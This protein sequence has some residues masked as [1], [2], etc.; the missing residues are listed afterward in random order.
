MKY[1][2]RISTLLLEI[3]FLREKQ[4]NYNGAS[5]HDRLVHHAIE[6]IVL[7]IENWIIRLGENTDVNSPH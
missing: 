3:D 4:K 5:S 7:K 6:Q 2:Y 1:N